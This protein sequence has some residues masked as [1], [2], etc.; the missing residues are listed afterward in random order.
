MDPTDFDFLDPNWQKYSDLRIR[1]QGAR[2]QPKTEEKKLLISKPKS[3]LLKKRDFK[4]FP[5]F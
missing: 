2:Y 5:D 4:K 3:E 1:I